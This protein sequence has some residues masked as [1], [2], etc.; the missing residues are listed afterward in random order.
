MKRLYWIISLTTSTTCMGI[1]PP[2]LVGYVNT[3]SPN[4][5]CKVPPWWNDP[6]EGKVDPFFIRPFDPNYDPY[7][8][9]SS[10]QRPKKPHYPSNWKAN[11]PPPPG[12][13]S[14]TRIQSTEQL[15]QT[16]F[17]MDINSFCNRDYRCEKEGPHVW[18]SQNNRYVCTLQ[19][20]RNFKTKN[21]LNKYYN[22]HN[23]FMFFL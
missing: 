1:M 9:T 19:A 16:P 8:W 5:R 21:I 23:T 3:V 11:T 15:C 10:I 2:P 14:L 4:I 6:F 12:K 13:N 22:I 7:T 17:Y 20:M 18:D